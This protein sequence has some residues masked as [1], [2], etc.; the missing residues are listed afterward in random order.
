MNDKIVLGTWGEN[1]EL[2]IQDGKLKI[3]SQ[4]PI[5]KDKYGNLLFEFERN[6]FMKTVLVS[7]QERGTWVFTVKTKEELME[8]FRKLA[9]RGY[10]FEP[11][12]L[13]KKFFTTSKIA[14]DITFIADIVP[15]PA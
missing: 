8:I 12:P 13:V 7:T 1:I 2:V 15:V 11:N 9:K 3:F 6:S 5:L 14:T 4:Y 10:L